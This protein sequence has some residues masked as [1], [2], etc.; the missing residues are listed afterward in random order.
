M[1]NLVMGLLVAVS[2][3]LST[4]AQLTPP[5]I[6]NIF[7]V[8]FIPPP[9]AP[10]LKVSTTGI[11]GTNFQLN[12]V[13]ADPAGTYDIYFASN[14]TAEWNDIFSGTNGQTNFALSAPTTDEGYFKATRTDAAVNDASN[15]MFSFS[16]FYI[17]TNLISA[18][19]SN[20]VATAMAVLVNNTNFNAAQ[21]IPFS[22]VPYILLGTNDGSYQVWV[23]LTGS[24]GIAYWTEQTVVLDR[25]PMQ[26]VITNLT[27]Y[28]GSRP[29]IDP[30]GYTTKALQNLTFQVNNNGATQ[31]GNGIAIAETANPA[32]PLYITNWFQ[33]LD[34]PLAI[35]TNHITITGTD[36]AG[37]V[38]S[39]NFD[40]LLE[41][42]DDT[43]PPTISLIWPQDGTQIVGTNFTVQGM[44][45]DD[46][47]TVTAQFVDTNGVTNTVSGD[48]ERGGAF[49]LDNLPL[50]AGTNFVTIT[51]TDF[52]G[53]TSV[54]NLTLIQSSFSLTINSLSDSALENA[55]ATVQGYVSDTNCDI[56][57]NGVEGTNNGDGTWEVDNVPLPSG[58]TV[59]LVAKAQSSTTNQTQ[60]VGFRQPV[61]FVQTYSYKLDDNFAS[62]QSGVTNYYYSQHI[63]FQWARG[64]GGHNIVT[65]N[66]TNVGTGAID[67]EIDD[68]EWPP[69]NG[70]MPSLTAVETI[71]R[72]HDGNP[73]TFFTNAYN[74]LPFEWMEKSVS[75]GSV[76]YNAASS[77]TES[78]SR[79]VHL[80]TG[81]R[82][83]RTKQSLFCLSE[84]LN[85]EQ[86]LD[87]NMPD[88]T[89]LYWSGGLLQGGPGIPANQI[90]LG[91][92]GKLGD[93]GNLWT[94]LQDNQEIDIT[95]NAPVPAFTGGLPNQ[96]KYRLH[97]VVN[98]TTPLS[99]DHVVAGA[100]YCVGQYLTFAPVWTPALPDTTVINPIEWTFSGAFVNEFVPDLS[101]DLASGYYTN[102]PALL[103]VEYP[104]AWWISGEFDPPATYSG[105]VGEGLTFANGQYVAIATSGEFSMFR[106]KCSI[107]STNSSY[108][109]A[110]VPADDP[111]ELQLGDTN[112]YMK[113]F[114]TI[115]SASPFSGGANI[116]QLANVSRSVSNSHGGVSQTTD[117][118]F[119]LDN[120][121]F[122]LDTDIP[123][124][125]STPFSSGDYFIDQPGY[126]LNPIFG[127]T[128]CSIVD[129]FKDYIRFRPDGNDNNIYITVGR[130]FWDWSASTTKSGDLWNPPT[131]QVN[132]PSQ[133]DNSN[134]MPVWPNTIFDIG[135]PSE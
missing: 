6:T 49:W 134:E 88:W 92:L 74:N 106:P 108:Y 17:S 81:G 67:I 70:Y 20:G 50:N 52:A 29:F 48:V 58:G 1:K 77:Y 44:L 61:V 109:A 66:T 12:L 30:A 15:M 124:G 85:Q 96:Q 21:W 104:A 34:L 19:V 63:D 72:W 82:A 111:D 41:T 71:H 47:A 120:T 131:Y 16:D 103:A 91:A 123:I 38:A 114:V 35:G 64:S 118:Q 95:P 26:L 14:L 27:A 97:I 98:G 87:N 100:N 57:V 4:F 31:T 40:Y 24:N 115:T 89:V 86:N 65:L 46:T 130:V 90:T 8:P 107:S 3:S 59:S 33:C 62:T 121:E 37:N 93:D 76:P 117:G 125:E 13:E 75:S 80:F 25:T 127:A 54:T 73:R 83:T 22:S 56:S 51:A 68:Y 23:G 42:N 126:G 53:N 78:A 45:D 132:G 110:L 122:Y 32:N 18:S 116:T 60:S 128:M 102:N 99:D 133:P 79:E 105:T 36:W 43:T 10:G 69:D 129:S 39:T 5:G 101:S 55:Y 112:G 119:W 84:G 113:Y 28:T 2:V 9:Y 7:V 94:A 11:V 135:A